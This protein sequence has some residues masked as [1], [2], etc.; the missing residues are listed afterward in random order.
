MKTT[1]PFPLFVCCILILSLPGCEKV[2]T[3]LGAAAG[4]VVGGVF[5]KDKYKPLAIAAGVIAGGFI[6]NKI[7]KYL[8]ERDKQ[9]MQEVTQKAIITGKDQS[10]TNPEAKTRGSARVVSTRTK[11]EPVKV[12]VL[13]KKVTQV[14]PLEMLG[15][16][17]RAVK[18]A[19]LRGGPGTDYEIVGNLTTGRVVN[20]VGKVR[21]Q[22]WYLVSEDGVGSGFAEVASLEP[23]PNEVPIVSQ[24]QATNSDVSEQEV[25]AN[26]VCRK[27]EQSV[28]LP[29]GSSH[30]DT[31]DA[32]QG[33]NGWEKA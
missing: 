29:D 20:A 17:F 4:G 1:K 10:W 28:S 33:P 16:T 5:A 25:T 9:R 15:Q 30:S 18:T 14:P 8:D 22:D 3:G 7:G 26:R 12:K 32:C 24:G 13:K 31:I 23:A 6:G 21:N 11:E 2:G 27:I 19:D